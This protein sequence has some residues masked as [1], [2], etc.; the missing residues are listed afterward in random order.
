MPADIDTFSYAAPDDPRLK[1]FVIRLIERMTG[2]PRLRRIYDA[3][4]SSP[5]PGES[6]WDS[7]VRRLG[8]TIVTNVDALARL[9]RTGPLVAVANHPFGVLDGIIICQLIGRMRPDFRV[10]TNAV[11]AKADEIREHLLPVDFA[12]TEEA[13]E[14]NLK[15]RAA[16]KHHLLAGGCLIV[17]PA[18]GVSTTPKI[19]DKNATDAEWKNL[20]ARL[21][22]QSRACVVPVYFAG[23]NSR[24]FQ[25]ASHLSLTLR[26]SL[27]FK[28][29]HDRIGTE[30]HV[31]IGDVMAH[32]QLAAI[33]DREKFM[34]TLRRATYALG[35]GLPKRRRGPKKEA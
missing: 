22:L 24:L 1:R 9:P 31:R 19:W 28:E 32:A 27:L 30:V 18:G 8:L 23:Q 12:E 16:A 15:S 20:T 21:I 11:L 7:A 14:T 29:V 35:Q 10:L 26:L 2:Q 13:L 17:F 5:V 34:E 6:F 25:L 3:H 4:R 33:N